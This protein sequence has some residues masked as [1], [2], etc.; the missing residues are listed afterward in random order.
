MN[1]SKVVITCPGCG[2]QIAGRMTLS[3]SKTGNW[4]AVVT[5]EELH[6]EI[7][8]FGEKRTVECPACWKRFKLEIV[9]SVVAHAAQPN[10]AFTGRGRVNINNKPPDGHAPVQ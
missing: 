10:K 9:P 7:T 1:N 5:I 6:S 8:R 3:Y 4:K 2:R